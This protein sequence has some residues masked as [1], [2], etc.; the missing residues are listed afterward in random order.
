MTEPCV[1]CGSTEAHERYRNSCE[2]S[3]EQHLGD[4]IQSLKDNL[5][6][7][8]EALENYKKCAGEKR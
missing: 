8:E 7:A 1:F 4:V 2:L 3:D 6:R 5:A